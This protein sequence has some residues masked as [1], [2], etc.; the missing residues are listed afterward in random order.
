MKRYLTIAIDFDDTFTADE[1][2]WKLFIDVA[3]MR[4]HNVICI[5]ARNPTEDNVRD[6]PKAI[7]VP[8][9]FT[10][11]GEKLKFSEEHGLSVDIWIDDSPYALIH[12]W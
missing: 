6:V 5:T 1:E 11:G 9:Y 10:S 8:V 3:K 2:L 7:G 4:G 12:G